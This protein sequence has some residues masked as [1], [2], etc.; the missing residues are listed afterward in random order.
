[1]R[2][3]REHCDFKHGSSCGIVNSVTLSGFRVIDCN[4]RSILTAPPSCKFAALSYV[5]G[6]LAHTHANLSPVEVPA[7]APLLIEDAITCTQALGLRYL[8]ID[9]YC[10]DQTDTHTKQLLIRNM[11]KIYQGA[12]VTLINVANAGA[13]GGLPGVSSVARESQESLLVKD[14]KLIYIPAGGYTIGN[15][16]WSTRGWTYQEGLLARHR[17]IFSSEQVHFQCFQ[18]HACEMIPAFFLSRLRSTW[19]ENP[20]SDDLQAFPWGA[21]INPSDI[22]ERIKAYAR[23]ELKHESNALNAF[24]G[25]LNQFWQPSEPLYHLWGLPFHTKPPKTA[26]LETQLSNV[27]LWIP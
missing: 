24:L 17:L 16:K 23:R 13:E 12:T 20:L 8:W 6:A 19:Q 26:P 9:R 5:W 25:V 4:T 2:K 22:T 27:L 21:T 14:R 7:P 15:S 11:D 18:E 1:V 10:I 3:W